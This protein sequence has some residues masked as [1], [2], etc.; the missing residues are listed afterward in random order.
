[1]KDAGVNL[2][3]KYMNKKQSKQGS[4]IHVRNL[5]MNDGGFCKWKAFHA[6]IC[7]DH[8]Y[9]GVY[10]SMTNAKVPVYSFL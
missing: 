8:K 7:R 1:M 2:K 3:L 4:N 6:H 10:H 9:K 5:L